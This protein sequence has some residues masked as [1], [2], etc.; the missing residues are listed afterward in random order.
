PLMRPEEYK[1]AFQSYMENVVE[2]KEYD[3]LVSVNTVKDYLWDNNGPLN[4]QANKN[5]TISQDLPDIYRVTN[6]C[7]MRDKESTMKEE[8]FLGE[9]PYKHV[10]GKLSGIDIDEME[11]YQ[12]A[13]ALKD[14]Y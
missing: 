9:K 2:K 3:S 12:M 7:Y 11:D 13:Y 8:Y 1:E 4:Y 6:G 14:I 5:H 10:V